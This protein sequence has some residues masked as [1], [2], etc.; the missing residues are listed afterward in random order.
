MVEGCRCATV[1][2]APPSQVEKKTVAGGHINNI[3]YF[4]LFTTISYE[5]TYTYKRG[6]PNQDHNK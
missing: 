1:P 2:Q 4:K 3:F 6:D 5:C